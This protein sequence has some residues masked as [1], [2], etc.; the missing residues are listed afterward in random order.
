MIRTI[1]TF[2]L[3][4]FLFP[5]SSA[6]QRSIIKGRVISGGE[7]VAYASV[8]LKGTSLGAAANEAGY[9][10]FDDVHYNTYT[11]IVSAVGFRTVEKGVV[12]D[13]DLLEVTIR[14]EPD[15]KTLDEVVVTGTMKEVSRLESPVPVEVFSPAFFAANPTPNLFESIGQVNGIRPQINCNVCNTG[16]I[17][18]NGME[19]P[20][21]LVLIDGMPI[22]SSLSSVYG[23]SGIPNSL[24][25]RIEIVKGPASSLYG[26]EAMGG[27]INV[28]TKDPVKAPLFSVDFMSTSWQE[29]N[30]DLAVKLKLSQNSHL[31]SGA[32]YFRYDHPVDHNEDGFTDMTLQN[33]ISLFNKWSMQRTKDRS[34]DI[35]ARYVYEDR[36]GGEMNWSDTWRGSDSIYGESIYTKRWEII[37]TYQFPVKPKIYFNGSFNWHDQNSFYGNTPY[38][39]FQRVSF[40]QVYW[41][42][43]FGNAHDILTGI[44]FRHIYYDDNTPGTSDINQRNQAQQTFLPGVFVQDEVQIRKDQSLLLGFRFDHDKNHGSIY[45]PRIA[46]KWMPSR[47]ST[48]R[49]SF[50]TGFRVVNL[51]T[52]DHAAL[53]GSREVVIE[54]TLKPERSVSGNLNYVIRFPREDFFASL[55]LTGFYTYFTNKIIGDFDT[56]P[57]KILYNNLTG[58]ALTRGF[59]LNSE[60]VFNFPLKVLSGITFM[61]VFRV[62]ETLAGT[63]NKQTQF[64]APKWSGNF[65]I[66]YTF[67]S[68]NITLDLTGQWNGPM[69]LPVFPN[70]YRR[71]YSPWFCLMNLQITK[72][73]NNGLEVYGGIKNLLNFLPDDPLLRPFDPFDKNIDDL[74]SNPNGYTFDTTYNYAPLQGIRGF[75]GLRYSIL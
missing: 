52:E 54:E 25:E 7:P 31:L 36:W 74:V 5:Y 40:A 33:R 71:E 19:G 68:A 2:L 9:F 17:H 67:P 61:D 8:G 13:R 70:D 43:P 28:I 59:S 24:V 46:Y 18:I 3:I 62:D 41:S 60:L 42:E 16:D 65:T 27:I 66:G 55:D 39:A 63:K 34:F 12:A 56:D 64:H 15:N 20:Y 26:S 22:V 48:L 10:Q 11:L 21:T 53:T 69:R 50:G 51:F 29:Y 44:T 4:V 45:S 47:N 35:A 23:L 57:E 58:H 30:T 75:V 49:A 37:S 73:F 14:L 1:F 38:M 32:N 72:K 6:Q